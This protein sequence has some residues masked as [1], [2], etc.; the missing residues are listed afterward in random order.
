[1]KPIT[2]S[3][4]DQ[5][6]EDR[7]KVIQQSLSHFCETLGS[8]NITAG[9][10]LFTG[11]MAAPEPCKEDE[12]PENAFRILWGTSGEYPDGTKWTREATPEEIEKYK[13]WCE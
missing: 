3:K 1:M 12:E 10:L 2:E 7:D 6:R 11:E 8:D 13:S 5:N 9:G 4:E